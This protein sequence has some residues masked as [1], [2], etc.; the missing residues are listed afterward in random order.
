MEFH[1]FSAEEEGDRERERK[2][3]RKRERERERTVEEIVVQETEI[4]ATLHEINGG[5]R[6]SA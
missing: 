6:S 2:R 5:S 1:S 3:Y 4:K